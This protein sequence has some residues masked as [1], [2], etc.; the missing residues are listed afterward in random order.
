MGSR[1]QGCGLCRYPCGRKKG[2]VMNCSPQELKVP[3]IREDLE[4]KGLKDAPTYTASLYHLP[5]STN[6]M[7]RQLRGSIWSITHARRQTK[8]PRGSESRKKRVKACR[9]GWLDGLTPPKWKKE[10][11]SWLH[12]QVNQSLIKEGL[13][14]LHPHVAQRQ[15][16][17]GPT[18][19]SE[20]REGRV[21][22]EGANS[23]HIPAKVKD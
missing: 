21:K 15:R 16:V 4:V 7:C 14:W 5:N 9:R 3:P 10:G 18:C 11:L 17:K 13:S 22:Q 2:V 6:N 23:T 8:D 19:G 12:P 20:S 1:Q